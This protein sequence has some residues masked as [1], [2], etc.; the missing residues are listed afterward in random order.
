[1]R[2]NRVDLTP[3]TTLRGFLPPLSVVG[4][5]SRLLITC[6]IEE[7]TKGVTTNQIPHPRPSPTPPENIRPYATLSVLLY[8]RPRFAEWKSE[9]SRTRCKGRSHEPTPASEACSLNASGWSSKELLV[10]PPVLGFS[11]PQ[12]ERCA[13]QAR[14]QPC[15]QLAARQ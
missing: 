8:L 2:G 6:H 3:T 10:G 7:T 15:P 9:D 11:P 1:M 14:V 5:P 13:V 4:G 12:T